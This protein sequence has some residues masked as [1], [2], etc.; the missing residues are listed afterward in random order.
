MVYLLP[1]VEQG[2]VWNQ[3]VFTGNSGFTNATN[4]ATSNGLIIKTYRCPSSPLPMTA[5]SASTV[6]LANYVGISGA[7]SNTTVTNLFAANP[8][9]N[10]TRVDNHALLMNCCAGGGPSG[11]GGILFRGSLVRIADISDGMSNFM[12]VSEHGDFFLAS[13]GSRRPWTAGGLH[14][15]TMGANSNRSSP[16]GPNPD[17]RQFNCTTIRYPINQK[18]NWSANGGTGTQSGD[19]RVGVCYDLGN[20]IPLNS[21]H[22][23][24]VVALFGDGS[25]RFLTDATPL[26]TL[27]RLATRD[28]GTVVSNF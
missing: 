2:N 28:D 15:W 6:M 9:F 25:C 5:Q 17:N 11:S 27:A 3:W 26:S 4:R 18:R 8:A 1:Y 21:A 19:C 12:M 20:N 23:G 14:G 7:V 16:G 10:E 22:P 13:D 24:G